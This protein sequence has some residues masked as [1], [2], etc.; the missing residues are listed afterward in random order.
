MMFIAPIAVIILVLI[1]GRSP[2]NAGFYGIITAFFFGFI[3]PDLRKNPKNYF[4]VSKEQVRP[5]VNY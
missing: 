1:D 5:V 3:N 2:A 4:L